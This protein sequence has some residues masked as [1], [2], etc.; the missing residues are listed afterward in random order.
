MEASEPSR[1]SF[2]RLPKQSLPGRVS[3]WSC[4]ALH[5]LRYRGIRRSGDSGGR[6][7]AKYSHE[8]LGIVS[9]KNGEH[10]LKWG[11][12]PLLNTT[13]GNGKELPGALNAAVMGGG[14]L[15]IVSDR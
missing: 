3:T 8:S 12:T 10:P 4:G 9:T 13:Y 6:V 11:A 1:S 15:N 7:W 14:S 5:R 2:G